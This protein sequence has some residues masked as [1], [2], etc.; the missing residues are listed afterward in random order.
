MDGTMS[1]PRKLVARA[2]RG[3][4]QLQTFDKKRKFVPID[5]GM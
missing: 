4:N 1:K 2:A 3:M 5:K